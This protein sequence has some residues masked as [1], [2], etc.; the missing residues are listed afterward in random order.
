[1]GASQSSDAAPHTA[2]HVLRVAPN[3]PA[4]LAN[5]EPF[6]DYIVGV[7][8]RPDVA[9]KLQGDPDAL[10]GLVREGVEL[11][12]II[13]S[14]KTRESRLVPLTPSSAWAPLGTPDGDAGALLG[15]SARV[16]KATTAGEHVWHVLDVLENSPAESAGLVPFGDWIVGWSGGPLTRERDFYEVIEAHVEQPL[17]VYVYSYDFDTLREVVLVPNRQWGG[18]GLLGCVF[19]YGVLHRIP[20]MPTTAEEVVPSFSDRAQGQLARRLSVLR[21]HRRAAMSRRYSSVLIGAGAI[22]VPMTI[23]TAL[24][25]RLGSRAVKWV[26]VNALRW[27]LTLV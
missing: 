16:C 27:P 1:M 12:L 15:L 14:S 22:A 2:L 8:G 7:D 21:R 13:W 17:R 4:S 6:F 5:V 9:Q 25:I 11:T 24:C 23:E 18:E 10:A 19:G 3:S 20:T 26:N